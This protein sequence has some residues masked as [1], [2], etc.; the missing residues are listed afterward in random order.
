MEAMLPLH[1]LMLTSLLASAPALFGVA[2]FHARKSRRASAPA[3]LAIGNIGTG[4]IS[5]LAT[6][7]TPKKLFRA[8][9][10]AIRRDV[11]NYLPNPLMGSYPA[12]RF[13]QRGAGLRSE[14]TG[15]LAILGT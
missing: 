12:A 9:P 15:A 13:C 5:T 7:S 14:R 1:T 8:S 4:N 11:L 10:C 2:G 3:P 6:F